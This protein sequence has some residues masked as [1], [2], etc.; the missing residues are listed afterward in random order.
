MRDHIYGERSPTHQRRGIDIGDVARNLEK[1]RFSPYNSL[2]KRALIWIRHTV[3]LSVRAIF[4]VAA[5]T[6]F[7]QATSVGLMTPS[8]TIT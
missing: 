1:K 5:Q 2:S 3:Y 7:V 4:V 8:N 6:L